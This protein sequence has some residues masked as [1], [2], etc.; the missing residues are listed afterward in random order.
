MHN[1]QGTHKFDLNT[2]LHQS[3]FSHSHKTHLWTIALRH[4]N[5]SSS[6]S[7]LPDGGI[8]WNIAENVNA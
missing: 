8:E 3:N 4:H 5:R 7:A 6:I 1:T 2:K